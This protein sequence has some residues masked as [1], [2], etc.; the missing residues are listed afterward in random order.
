[1]KNFLEIFPQKS[2]IKNKNKLT[3]EFAKIAFLGI[4]KSL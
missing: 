4:L 2:I 3:V 1:M